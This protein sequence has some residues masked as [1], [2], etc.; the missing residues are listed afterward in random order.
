MNYRKSISLYI[1]F[2]K[3]AS[4]GDVVTSFMFFSY[5]KSMDNHEHL[6]CFKCS[7]TWQVTFC[8]CLLKAIEKQVGDTVGLVKIFLQ[9]GAEVDCRDSTG[10]SP[11]CLA[12]RN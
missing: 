12:A 1:L 9:R 10:F 3:G 8:T 4:G 6:L 5:I 2:I 7:A 11:L